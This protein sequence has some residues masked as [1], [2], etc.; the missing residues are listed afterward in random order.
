[1]TASTTP[2]TAPIFVGGAGRSGTTLLRVILDAHPNI[3]CGPELKVTPLVCRMWHDFQFGYFPALQQ[4]HLTAEDLAESFRALLMSFLAK[5]CVH[6]GKSRVAEK[7]PNN[8]FFFQQLHRL[9]PDS[10]L[11]HVIRDGRDVVCSLLDMDWRNPQT[12]ERIECTRDARGAAKYWVQAVQAGRMAAKQPSLAQ[13]YFELRYEEMIRAPETTLRPL[14]AFL[15]EAW[16]P[17]VL[18]YHEQQRDLGGESSAHQVARP[19]NA[20]ALGR[21]QRDL[22]EADKNVVKELAGPLLQELGY[23]ADQSW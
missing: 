21:W 4:H 20:Q 15:G 13:R 6:A 5:D 1:M 17:R 16:D 14:F 19:I 2:S 18:R 3:V 23:A 12:G 9:F 10:P 22:R 8:V 11:I 7:S